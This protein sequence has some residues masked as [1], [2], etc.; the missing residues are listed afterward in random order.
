MSKIIEVP[1]NV[2]AT[3]AAVQK[4]MLKVAR[5]LYRF[6]D[7]QERLHEQ[8]DVITS[9]RFRA[10]EMPGGE[11]LAVINLITSDGAF[12]G[13]H[14]DVSFVAAVRGVCSRV[15]NGSIKWKEDQYANK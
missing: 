1:G 10:P 7:R 2:M 13:F 9:V 14:S 12:V 3:G 6:D 15:N 5:E 8:G 4:E 11:W